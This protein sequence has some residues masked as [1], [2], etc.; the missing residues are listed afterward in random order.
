MRSVS[1]MY[2]TSQSVLS[3]NRR[4][5]AA[6]QVTV[7]VT[8][9]GYADGVA[10]RADGK[11]FFVMPEE[12]QMSMEQF[13]DALDNRDKCVIC[14]SCLHKY[15]IPALLLDT[16]TTSRSKTPTSPMTLPSFVTI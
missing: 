7:A 14:C 5:L 4:I 11:E 15:I 2:L 13:L 1:S 10:S 9:N 6:K 3:H 16:S 8:P 12:Q